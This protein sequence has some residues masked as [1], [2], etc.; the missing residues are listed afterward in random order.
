[1]KLEIYEDACCGS[2]SGSIKNVLKDLQ[3]H[4][5]DEIQVEQINLLHNSSAVT[6]PVDVMAALLNYGKKALPLLVLDNKVLSKG[7]AVSTANVVNAIA[8]H[9][10]N[11][12]NAQAEPNRLMRPIVLTELLLSPEKLDYGMVTPQCCS[13]TYFCACSST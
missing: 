5:K 3:D 11:A 13:T 10:E 8:T 4:Y 1:M 6:V 2:G 12:K 9:K 7:S